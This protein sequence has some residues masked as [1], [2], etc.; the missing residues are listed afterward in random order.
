MNATAPVS[1]TALFQLH[2]A[3]LKLRYAVENQ[4]SNDVYLVNRLTRYEKDKGWIPD[5]TVAYVFY[6]PDVKT[7]AGKSVD[8]VE[9]AKR[10]PP[11]PERLVNPRNYYVTPLRPGAKFE[12]ELAFPIPLLEHRPYDS[13]IG[14]LPPA[15]EVRA[16]VQFLLGFFPAHPLLQ[17]VEVE[18]HDVPAFRLLPNR[19][20]APAVLLPRPAEVVLASR[21]QLLTL[22]V[23]PLPE[24]PG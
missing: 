15:K 6:R 9:V 19:E 7:E 23:V 13:F 20:P 11:M 17:V 10:V 8:R 16:E 24:P 5:P 2:P 22:R 3:A 1:L 18:V 21:P 12:E 4:G 14:T